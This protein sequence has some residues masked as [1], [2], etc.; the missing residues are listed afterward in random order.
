VS[1]AERLRN[2][3]EESRNKPAE[4]GVDDC[5]QW[6]ANW[7]ERE[8]GVILPRKPYGSKDEARALITSAGSL[9]AL[10]RDALPNAFT[11]TFEPKA[12][13]V[14]IVDTRVFGPVGCVFTRPG[15]VAWRAEKGVHVFAPNLK[16][17]LAAWRVPD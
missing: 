11:E 12:G 6:A 3:C 8:T 15:I 9:V 1:R 13:D 17:L 10:W 4:W 14:A 7:V 16:Y 2:Y 5:T